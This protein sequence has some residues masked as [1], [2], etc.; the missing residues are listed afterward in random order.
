MVGYAQTTPRVVNVSTRF[1]GGGTGVG[2]TATAVNFLVEGTAS[3]PVLIRAV[4]PTLGTFG[5]AGVLADPILTLYGP[6]G[7][8]VAENND[9]GGTQPLTS[10][11]ISVGSFS[12]PVGSK[13]AALLYTAAPGGYTAI[14]SG[15]NG[16]T[17]IALLEV[18]E[19]DSPASPSRMPYVAYRGFVG[20]GPDTAVVG[21]VLGGS[22]TSGS[23]PLLMRGLGPALGAGTPGAL[24]DPLLTILGGSSPVATNDNWDGS[25]STSAAAAT[26][27]LMAFDAG[28]RDAAAQVTLSG[29]ANYTL[30]LTGVGGATGI[31]MIEIAQLDN[32]AASFAP[33]L[34]I[35]PYPVASA[36]GG[37]VALT[38]LAIGR[39]APAY[40]WRKD[41]S[42]IAGATAPTLALTN[43]QP[44]QAGSYSVVLS[45]AAGI[46]TST[47]YVVTV[48]GGSG[49]VAPNITLQPVAQSVA[50]GGSVTFSVVATG[51]TPLLYQWF[52]D[53]LPVSDGGNATL[54]LTNVQPVSGGAYTV[55]VTNAQGAVTS[56]P[57]RLVVITQSTGFVAPTIL[58]P[59]VA[60]TVQPGGA[61]TL[62][63]V[64]SG[65]APL[66]YQWQRNGTDI[67]G[68]TTPTYT[69]SAAQAADAGSY[70]C[71]VSNADG[72][73]MTEPVQVTVQF[74]GPTARLTN[75]SILTELSGAGDSFTLGYAVAGE[76]PVPGKSLLIRAAGP[77][78]GALGVAGT[79]QDPKL[80]LFV[81]ATKASE[82][83]D[84][85]GAAAVATAMTNVG[86]FAFAAT[87]KD[88]A[89]LANVTTSDNSVRVSASGSGTILAEI[90]DA[91]PTDLATR[92]L[93]NVSVLKPI[94]AGL[95]AG[96][97]IGGTGTKKV[98]IRA[99]GPSLGTLFNV[100]GA[101]ADPQLS[102]FAGQTPLA[103][104][105]NW[106]GTS[107]LT[108]AFT[109][110]G[111]FGLAADSRDAAV[112]VTLEPGSYSVRVA[113]V[114]GTTG[115]AIVE[116]YEVP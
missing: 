48:T 49:G 83:E 82:N 95:T 115:T 100:P 104:N 89:T 91:T 18:Y 13:D 21:F 42:P 94:G 68:A 17:G 22:G 32:R 78:L 96:F 108:E 38:A 65:R 88:A 34:L 57:A 46:T 51:T 47:E 35:P 54:T 90:Y 102:L 5:V 7:A 107:A 62:T 36:A 28:S 23:I 103:S 26:A 15:A 98:L 67:S 12:L 73:V 93:V 8:K 116:V 29:N 60:Q 85:G 20:T 6:N 81:G 31:G 11:F 72:R 30:Q 105:D 2:P 69:L 86:A 71:V 53:G 39:P 24:A 75:L 44:S 64:A 111:A 14:V 109:A 61:M 9:W 33:A 101:V 45:N 10:A 58:T 114:G 43:V 16:A 66:S 19:L 25:G 74:P 113:G 63:V 112:L 80:E 106:G 59:P 56:A 99:V 79:V 70:V 37:N 3:Q 97:V 40:Q 84:W 55:R 87:S 50:A 110:V 77:A 76:S 92:R 27:G 1:L 52:R 41:A 4:G